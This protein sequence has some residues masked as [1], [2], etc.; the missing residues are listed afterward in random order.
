MSNTTSADS[1]IPQST[2]YNTS[3]NT[4]Y[5]PL[6]PAPSTVS[7]LSNNN[8]GDDNEEID[9]DETNGDDDDTNN[10]RSGARNVFERIEGTLRDSGINFDISSMLD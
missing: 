10:E 3:Q 4:I 5:S 7:P 6:T 9:I 1:P 2:T 8:V